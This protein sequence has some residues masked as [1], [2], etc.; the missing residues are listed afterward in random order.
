MAE[1]NLVFL[2]SLDKG[3]AHSR[4]FVWATVHTSVCGLEMGTYRAMGFVRLLMRISCPGCLKTFKKAS[5][6]IRLLVY[7]DPSRDCRHPCYHDHFCCLDRHYYD[8]IAITSIIASITTMIAT[9]IIVAKHLSF[10]IGF[11]AP[12]GG[13]GRRKQSRCK[14]SSAGRDLRMWAP[15]MGDI[16]DMWGYA[17]PLKGI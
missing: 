5:R 12:G 3:L 10:Y 1:R 8:S 7:E 15:S 2:S 4:F 14:P 17:V 13:L 6:Q 9:N 11:R 16:V